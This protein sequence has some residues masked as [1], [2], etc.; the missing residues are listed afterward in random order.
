MTNNANSV[1]QITSLVADRTFLSETAQL[2]AKALIH[3]LTPQVPPY[4]WTYI[5]SR[6]IRNLTFV[7]IQLENMGRNNP[8]LLDRLDS[9]ARKTALVW[10]A[11]AALEE[12]TSREAALI[13]AAISFELAGYQANAMCLAK[14]IAESEDAHRYGVIT[15]DYLGALFIQRRFLQVGRLANELQQEPPEDIKHEGLLAAIGRALTSIAL[16]DG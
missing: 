1:D 11:F 16:S 4:R 9:T 12:G 14:R 2:Q 10:E 5:S 8:S 15:I 6:L 7:L 3:E 13:N